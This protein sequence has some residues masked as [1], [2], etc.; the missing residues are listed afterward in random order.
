MQNKDDDMIKS[1]IN[2]IWV[3]VVV[4]FVLTACAMGFLISEAKNIF[5]G[6]V[7]RIDHAIEYKKDD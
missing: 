2:A 4:M 3:L 7:D 6:V 5:D 1:K